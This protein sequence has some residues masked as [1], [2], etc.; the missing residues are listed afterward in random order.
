[1]RLRPTAASGCARGTGNPGWRVSKSP[2]WEPTSSQSSGS[3]SA[4]CRGTSLEAPL[5][6][7]EIT[8]CRQVRRAQPWRIKFPTW[9]RL[10]CG[11]RRGG[12]FGI[13][14]PRHLINHL[15]HQVLGSRRTHY[16]DH[17]HG[18]FELLNG[19]WQVRGRGSRTRRRRGS[20]VPIG[21]CD[22]Q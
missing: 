19:G 1:M 10:W 12:F 4:A 2:L 3:Q 13:S 16:L 17:G 6:S 22:I 15:V 7:G 9:A 11:S 14:S 8:N 5:S 18:S 20:I 21:R